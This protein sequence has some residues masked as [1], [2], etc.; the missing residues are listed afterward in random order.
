MHLGACECK[1]VRYQLSGEP[2]TCYTCHCTD[3]QTVSGSAFGQTMIVKLD[4]VDVL[5][6]E[7]AVSCVDK[8]GIDVKRHHC[9]K[10]GTAIMFSADE[11]PGMGALRPGTFDD[12]SWFAPI[13]HLWVRSAQPWMVFDDETPQY[14]K[15][16]EISELIGLW[17][18]SQK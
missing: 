16:P 7:L 2:L 6:G 5:D 9:G 14:Q 1:A 17:S 13:A 15:Q 11:Y 8:N 12:T 3:C 10:C 18:A 4:D